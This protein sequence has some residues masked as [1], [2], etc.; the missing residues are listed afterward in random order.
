MKITKSQLKRIIQEEMSRVDEIAPLLLHPDVRE[1]GA[2]TARSLWDAARGGEDVGEALK[3]Q[4]EINADVS[5]ALQAI[6]NQV[7]EI[8]VRLDDVQFPTSET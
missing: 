1:F 5:E 8:S 6:A 2:K 3:T 7:N 4:D